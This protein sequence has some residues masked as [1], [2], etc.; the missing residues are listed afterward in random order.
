MVRV[1]DLQ[2]IEGDEQSAQELW[3]EKLGNTLGL[4]PQ[5]T[6]PTNSN[7]KTAFDRMYGGQIK[8]ETYTWYDVN[9]DIPVIT[10]TIGVV[11]GVAFLAGDGGIK[12]VVAKWIET[13]EKITVAPTETQSAFQQWLQPTGRKDDAVPVE[14]S[15]VAEEETEQDISALE[16]AEVGHAKVALG[17]AGKEPNPEKWTEVAAT[18]SLNIANRWLKRYSQ[19]SYPPNLLPVTQRIILQKWHNKWVFA[20]GNEIENRRLFTNSGF[21][22][23][24]PVAR[25]L[26]Q[27]APPSVKKV[28]ERLNQVE[29]EWHVKA[30]RGITKAYMQILTKPSSNWMTILKADPPGLPPGAP[31]IPDEDEGSPWKRTDY[32]RGKTSVMKNAATGE[33]F[34]HRTGYYDTTPLAEQELVNPQYEG[35]CDEVLKNGLK[36]ALNAMVDS[37]QA[38]P[39]V[40]RQK[41]TLAVNEL[42]IAELSEMCQH[43]ADIEPQGEYAKVR[44]QGSWSNLPNFKVLGMLIPEQITLELCQK[45]GDCIAYFM[46]EGVIDYSTPIDEAK[47]HRLQAEDEGLDVESD[48][49]AD[50]QGRYHE[51]ETSVVNEAEYGQAGVIKP[52]EMT[53]KER[54]TQMFIDY[55]RARV[56]PAGH[57]YDDGTGGKKVFAD[58]WGQEFTVIGL[59][60]AAKDEE[61][62]K[63]LE[64][65][66]K[67]MVEWTKELIRKHI[68]APVDEELQLVRGFRE[69][70]GIFWDDYGGEDL[71]KLSDEIIEKNILVYASNVDDKEE[72]EEWFEDLIEGWTY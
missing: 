37:G 34:M 22:E 44:Q 47:I 25:E 10:R 36:E 20:P 65:L 71:H 56:W 63:K 11:Q 45:Y 39:K 72:L 67:H 13:G 61:S 46:G 58:D 23:L 7:R 19:Q 40:T 26:F 24:A 17:E 70:F 54:R 18:S 30:P 6:W 64:A 9:A 33:V 59:L 57:K 31:K 43:D 49:Y 38:P 52:G 1:A 48:E 50:K 8:Y 69:F 27:R 4:S 16:P 68:K 2:I 62:K 60:E 28:I 35:A 41:I 3:F 5:Q 66:A 15:V 42:T 29:G 55:Q 53:E 21:V 32:L 14:E 51:G 12:E